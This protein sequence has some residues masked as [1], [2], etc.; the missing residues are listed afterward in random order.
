MKSF[1]KVVD[2]RIDTLKSKISKLSGELKELE[3]LNGNVNTMNA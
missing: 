1:D 2:G 3:K